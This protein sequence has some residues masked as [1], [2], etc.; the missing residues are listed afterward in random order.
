MCAPESCD[1][2]H[3]VKSS[4]YRRV[5]WALFLCPDLFIMLKILDLKLDLTNLYNE[6]ISC[7]LVRQGNKIYKKK[8]EDKYYSFWCKFKNA[9][10]AK[11]FIRKLELENGIKRFERIKNLYIS[12]RLI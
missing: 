6:S 1:S 9:T 7:I 8:V 11:K 5:N 4:I 12:S 2:P 10:R 3:Y